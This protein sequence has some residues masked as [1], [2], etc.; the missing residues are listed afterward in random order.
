MLM[1]FLTFGR[2]QYIIAVYNYY[3]RICDLVDVK[4]FQPIITVVSLSRSVN[5]LDLTLTFNVEGFVISQLS[6]HSLIWEHSI[7]S[8]EITS[9]VRILLSSFGNSY[10]VLW[11]QPF[12]GKTMLVAVLVGQKIHVYCIQDVTVKN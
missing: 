8:L 5:L 7:Y 11:S 6:D 9:L 3:A 2:C 1:G 4:N 12:T 10:K